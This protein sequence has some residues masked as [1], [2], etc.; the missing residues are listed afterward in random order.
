M[1]NRQSVMTLR[2]DDLVH[3]ASEFSGSRHRSRPSRT[4]GSHPR[5]RERARA[6]EIPAA[7]REQA[8]RR[9]RSRRALCHPMDYIE[10]IRNAAP[11]EGWSSS[12]PTPRCRPA[13]SRRRLPAIGGATRAVDEVVTGKAANA[14]CAHRPPGHHAETVR[15]MGFCIFNQAAIA[16]RT[17]RRSTAC[18]ASPW[19]TSTCTT[20]TARRTIFWSDPTLMYCSTHQ[21]PLYPGTGAVNETRRTRQH[22]QRAAAGR[23]RRRAVQAPRWR[24]H[25]AAARRLRPRTDHHFGRLRRP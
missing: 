6:G 16:A 10:E 5:D 2:Y 7:V 25:P 4:A 22:R 1:P 12:M 9:R 14:F 3:H 23:R 20:A 17:P 15:P 18:I 11:K 13:P 24:P 8:P 19:S 21:M